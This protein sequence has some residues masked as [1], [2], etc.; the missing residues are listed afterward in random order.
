[1]D[2]STEKKKKKVLVQPLSYVQVSHHLFLS[3]AVLCNSLF[4]FVFANLPETQKQLQFLFF[5]SFVWH[6]VPERER[7]IKSAYYCSLPCQPLVSRPTCEDSHGRLPG[8]LLA[9]A[10]SAWGKKELSGTASRIIRFDRRRKT[11]LKMPPSAGAAPARGIVSQPSKY[12][13]RAQQRS[14]GSLVWAEHKRDMWFLCEVESQDNTLL[15]VKN[16][17]TGKREEIDLVRTTHTRLY[18]HTCFLYLQTPPAASY[19]V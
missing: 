5:P 12:M 13:I 14:V 17:A 11:E 4:F 1:M 2:T 8:G 16:Q 19:F 18:I 15:R 9:A 3:C 10:E 7:C 6:W